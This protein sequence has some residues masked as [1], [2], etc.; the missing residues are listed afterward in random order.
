MLRCRGR[1]NES[2]PEFA[3]WTA[4]ERITE[5]ES[6]GAE[7]IVTSCPWCVKNFNDAIKENGSSIKV[8]DVVKLLEKAI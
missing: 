6:T 2:N 1:V 4:N 8:Y 5:A 7:A 3:K